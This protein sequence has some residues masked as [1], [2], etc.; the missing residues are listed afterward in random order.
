[1]SFIH[2]KSDVD[3]KAKLGKNVYV[4]AFAS[5]HADEGE[6]EIGDCTSIQESC[7]LHGKRVKIGSNVTV[8]HGAIVH[9]CELG[10]RVLVGMNATILCGAK[11][12]DDCI[13]A[14]GAVV[15]EGDIIPPKSIVMGVPGKVRRVCTEEDLERSCAKLRRQ[16]QKNGQI[17]QIK[18]ETKNKTVHFFLAPSIAAFVRAKPSTMFSFEAT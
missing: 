14:A 4:A 12:G 13:I 3:P 18:T 8:G 1:M 17:R 2:P 5:I 11:V 16:A 10:D 15:R 6:I 7:V 9:G